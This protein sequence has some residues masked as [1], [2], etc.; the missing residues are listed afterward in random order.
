M[1]RWLARLIDEVMFRYTVRAVELH[2]RTLHHDP[3]LLTALRTGRSLDLDIHDPGPPSRVERTPLPRKDGGEDFGFHFDSTPPYGQAHDTRVYG[4]LFAPKR[5]PLGAAV[6]FPGAFVGSTWRSQAFY[7]QLS[8]GFAARG[9]AAAVLEPPLHQRRAP[10]GERSGHEM[11]QGDI[12]THLRAAAQAVRDMRATIGWLERDYG[13][14]GYWGVS[15][16]AALGAVLAAADAR[17]RFT[18]LLQPPFHQRDVFDSA[19]GRNW[20]A[21]LRASGMTE[22]DLERAFN[23]LRPTIPPAAGRERL[24]IQAAR[25]DVIAPPAAVSALWELFHRPAL[26]WYDHSHISIFLAPQRIFKDGIDFA[27]VALRQDERRD[28]A[29]DA[30]SG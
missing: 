23:Q 13:A 12:F 15:L 3:A 18:V 1:Q 29:W 6:I 19:L 26:R 16:G 24:L 11:F 2:H 27:T 20:A 14:V 21:H 5:P 4:A 22:S 25:W 10:S 8:R 30:E 28:A 17:L 9:I 7:E